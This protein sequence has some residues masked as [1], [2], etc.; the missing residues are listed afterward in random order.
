M[1][2]MPSD[3]STDHFIWQQVAVDGRHPDGQSGW[4]W[5]HLSQSFTALWEAELRRDKSGPQAQGPQDWGPC[6]WGPDER[7][8]KAKK[9]TLQVCL[10][11][12][13]KY[14]SSR[15][16][17]ITVTRLSDFLQFQANPTGAPRV[18]LLTIGDRFGGALDAAAKQF[19]KAFDSGMLPMEFVN[20]A[21]WGPPVQINGTVVTCVLFYLYWLLCLMLFWGDMHFGIDWL[22]FGKR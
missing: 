22:N 12:Y 18:D 5:R 21:E 15:R 6:S 19:S 13:F 14:I 7:G 9:R 17:E 10:R 1:A 20:W 16:Q 8:R 3:S 11:S 2:L 4:H